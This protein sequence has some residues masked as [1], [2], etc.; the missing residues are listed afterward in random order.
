MF[1]LGEQTTIP[2]YELK[3]QNGE[4]RSYDALPIGFQLQ[5]LEGV[6]DPG[7]IKIVICKILEIEVD[8]FTAMQILQNFM[9]FAEKHIE[10][11]LK[12]V[13]GREFS[14]TTSMESRPET[15]KS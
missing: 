9:E 13:F 10:E 11:P 7:Q 2:N 14:S 3:L 12:N 6:D 15:S 5:C 1:D 8:A 4:T